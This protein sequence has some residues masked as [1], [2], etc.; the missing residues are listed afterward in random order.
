MQAKERAKGYF[1][2]VHMIEIG[3]D[4]GLRKEI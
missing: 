2:L 4:Y 3:N 1:D